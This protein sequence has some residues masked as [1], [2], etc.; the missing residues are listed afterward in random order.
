MFVLKL[1]HMF[2]KFYAVTKTNPIFCKPIGLLLSLAYSKDIIRVAKIRHI[3]LGT[4]QNNTS[5]PRHQVFD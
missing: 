3:S 4:M 1:H 2:S 5:V